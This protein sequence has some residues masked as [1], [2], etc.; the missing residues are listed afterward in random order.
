MKSLR[1]IIR[2]FNVILLSGLSLQSCTK[3]DNSTGDVK[4]ELNSETAMQ[5]ENLKNRKLDPELE[6]KKHVREVIQLIASIETET[7]RLISESIRY[8]QF[9]VLAFALDQD[10]KIKRS[11]PGFFCHQFKISWGKDAIDVDAICENPRQ[12]LAE[13][14]MSKDRIDVTFTSSKWAAVIGDFQAMT[15][16]DRF[17]SGEL[18]FKDESVRLKTLDCKNTVYRMNESSS[19]ELRLDEYSYSSATGQTVTLSGGVFRDLAK[20]RE[21]KLHVPVEGVIQIVEKELKVRDDFEHLLKKQE[22]K[23]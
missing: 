6:K 1:S 12:K 15:R 19:D 23:R 20:R 7:L 18:Q 8:N 13:I 3:K 2:I 22:G 10:L 16:P 21:I 4:A 5:G 14:R 9:Q 11:N 17:C